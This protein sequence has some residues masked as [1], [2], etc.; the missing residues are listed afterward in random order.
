MRTPQTFDDHD[1][2]SSSSPDGNPGKTQLRGRRITISTDEGGAYRD[3]VNGSAGSSRAPG[4][5]TI[6][7]L[8]L[9]PLAAVRG[10]PVQ[11]KRICTG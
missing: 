11:G 9:A 3:F 4:P 10:A 2:F 8:G 6:P 5:E 1:A 7:G